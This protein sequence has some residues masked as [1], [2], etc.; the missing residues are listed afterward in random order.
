M[1]VLTIYLS[2]SYA[3]YSMVFVEKITEVLAE[4]GSV[5]ILASLILLFD[6]WQFFFIFFYLGKMS[7]LKFT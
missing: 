5:M 1:Y 3:V 7:P 2:K 4:E 6:D